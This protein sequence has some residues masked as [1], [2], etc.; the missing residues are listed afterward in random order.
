MRFSSI[1]LGVV[2][3]LALAALGSTLIFGADSSPLRIAVLSS[4]MN[5]LDPHAESTAVGLAV[6]ANIYDQL[7][8]TDSEGRQ[9]PVLALSA[10]R[11]GDRTLRFQL[12]Q[13][14]KFHNGASFS[15]ADAV[16]SIL[17]A[18]DNPSTTT[19]D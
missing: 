7:L 3:L 1:K 6:Q 17:R 15:S 19:L 14:V 13:G 16:A 11:V 5:G 4:G 9:T 18:R 8:I 2:F 12:R 10:E